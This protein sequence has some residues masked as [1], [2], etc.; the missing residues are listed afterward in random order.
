[1]RR[2]T[3]E[4]AHKEAIFKQY[5]Q[6][7]NGPSMPESSGVMRRERMSVCHQRPKSMFASPMLAIPDL[8]GGS[9]YA[10]EHLGASPDAGVLAGSRRGSGERSRVVL[11][12]RLGCDGRVFQPSSPTFLPPHGECCS[13]ASGLPVVVVLSLLFPVSGFV[14][15]CGVSVCVSYARRN[16]YQS[17][18]FPSKV[19]HAFHKNATN[20]SFL[21]LS[22]TNTEN[23]GNGSLKLVQV[24]P[25][26]QKTKENNHKTNDITYRNNHVT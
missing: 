2:K 13:H 6:K 16:I 26:L 19:S 20:T 15:H 24:F 10:A 4:K 11:P 25:L 17:S 18:F 9:P 21:N 14:V 8:R 22:N 3:E 23:G 12:F 1:M 5:L 7:K